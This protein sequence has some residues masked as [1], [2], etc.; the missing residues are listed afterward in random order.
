[1]SH[2][3]YFVYQIQCFTYFDFK[4]IFIPTTITNELWEV[5]KFVK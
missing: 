1:M 4:V 5:S 3:N 2:K